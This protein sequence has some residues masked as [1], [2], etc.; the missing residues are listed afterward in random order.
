MLKVAVTGASRAFVSLASFSRCLTRPGPDTKLSAFCWASLPQPGRCLP[1]WAFCPSG[2]VPG[3]A[4]LTERVTTLHA[5]LGKHHR[6][7]HRRC[8]CGRAPTGHRTQGFPID[9]V[10]C[11]AVVECVVLCG[12]S[13]RQVQFTK[14]DPL[15]SRKNKRQGLSRE[16]LATR[17]RDCA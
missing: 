10:L 11:D 9:S 17:F 15:V 8:K 7:Q 2:G 1:L 4:G 6:H 14:G 12:C 13:Y 3:G 16:N 5:G